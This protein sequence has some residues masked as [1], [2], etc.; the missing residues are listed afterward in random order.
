MGQGM[1]LGSHALAGGTRIV[2]SGDL[3]AEAFCDLDNLASSRVMENAG[4]IRE[5]IL[6]RYLTHPNIS[7]DPRDCFLYAKVR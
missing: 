3:K 4:M 1:R 2:S 7:E 6:R 5:G